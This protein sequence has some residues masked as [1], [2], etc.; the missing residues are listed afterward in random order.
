MTWSPIL[1]VVHLARRSRGHELPLVADPAAHEA[2]RHRH[3]AMAGLD[4]SPV[5][6]RHC[7]CERCERLAGR[8]A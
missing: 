1:R 4:I 2:A 7:I 8:A 3:P 5:H 6:G